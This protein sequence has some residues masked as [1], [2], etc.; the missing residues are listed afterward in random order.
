MALGRDAQ[1]KGD[2]GGFLQR[3][4][5]GRPG[6][7]VTEAGQQ[8]NVGGPRTDAVDCGER[9]VGVFGGKFAERGKR[10]VA[11]G[12]GARDGLERCGFSAL[13]GRSAPAAPDGR[14]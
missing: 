1:R 8:I 3:Q 10:E 6:V 11:A 12:N 2:P 7:G 9:R 4:I 5:A 13:T 14:G